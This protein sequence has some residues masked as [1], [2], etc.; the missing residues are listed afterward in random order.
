MKKEGADSLNRGSSQL[1]GL[2]TG[3]GWGTTGW[4]ASLA[5]R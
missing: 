1:W 3:V 4:F 5:V 2:E